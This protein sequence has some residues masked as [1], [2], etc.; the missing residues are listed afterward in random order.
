[1]ALVTKFELTESEQKKLDKWM[2]K[3]NLNLYE[4]TI[5]GRFTYSFTPTSIGTIVVVKDA[6]EQ[7]DEINLTDYD[8]W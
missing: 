8:A 2:K 6:M 3:K 4:G 7:K 1:M 5:G